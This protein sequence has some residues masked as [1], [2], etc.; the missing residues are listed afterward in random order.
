MLA[1]FLP[2]RLES[3]T[4][5]FAIRLMRTFLT[6]GLAYFSS[7]LSRRIAPP[8]RAHAQGL[9]VSLLMLALAAHG[10]GT[11][12]PSPHRHR[13]VVAFPSDSASVFL[14]ANVQG[15]D[16]T[17]YLIHFADFNSIVPLFALRCLSSLLIFS[18]LMSCCSYLYLVTLCS[19]LTALPRWIL[20]SALPLLPQPLGATSWTLCFLRFG[21]RDCAPFSLSIS[22]PCVFG[23]YSPT[24]RLFACR[25]F[26][27]SYGSAL[28]SWSAAFFL[29]LQLMCFRIGLLHPL[30]ISLSC[31]AVR[32]YSFGVS[33]LVLIFHY[34]MF[35][36]PT[37]DIR[38]LSDSLLRP[39]WHLYQSP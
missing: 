8:A 6:P 19:V 31:G 26:I 36:P 25:L 30:V 35:V 21:I 15:D 34:S 28:A 33:F 1:G 5:L 3:P 11:R 10:H 37:S 9:R 39:W 2:F 20:L 32:F 14:S 4:L 7:R 27:L 24:H 22:R 16:F 12:L 23:L 13:A 18:V 17:H 29:C 38:Q